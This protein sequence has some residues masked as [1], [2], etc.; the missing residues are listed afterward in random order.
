V[1]FLVLARIQRDE[2][3]RYQVFGSG[4]YAPLWLPGILATVISAALVVGIA[5][6]VMQFLQ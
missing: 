1:L 4:E 3:G 2:D 5:L 6:L